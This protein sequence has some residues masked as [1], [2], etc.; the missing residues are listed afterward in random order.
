LTNFVSAVF[1]TMRKECNILI[2]ADDYIDMYP[3]FELLNIETCAFLSSSFL[4]L[5]KSERTGISSKEIFMRV[6]K[7]KVVC[8]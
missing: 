8:K 6:P 2:L 3:L 5:N 7:T 1:S 4:L